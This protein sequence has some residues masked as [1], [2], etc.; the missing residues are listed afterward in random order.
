MSRDQP[1]DDGDIGLGHAVF[2]DDALRVVV[3]VLHGV[4]FGTQK[5]PRLMRA[6]VGRPRR[7]RAA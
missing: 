6:E 1:A 2:V 4:G 5:G 3:G 7:T